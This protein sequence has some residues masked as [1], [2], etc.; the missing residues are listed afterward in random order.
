MK[1]PCMVNS[2]DWRNEKQLK[3][4]IFPTQRINV[5]ELQSNKK[6]TT[7][8]FYIK[9]PF[10]QVYSPLLAKKLVP[11]SQVIQ[12][13]EGEG[14]RGVTIMLILTLSNL[15]GGWELLDHLPIFCQPDNWLCLI[16]I[17]AYSDIISSPFNPFAILV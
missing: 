1:R 16:K 17:C 8:Y 11:L 10:F 4:F 6:V 13:F 3:N 15:G 5:V 7:P 9:P 12:F 2:K 14:K